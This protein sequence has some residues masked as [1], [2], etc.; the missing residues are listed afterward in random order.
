MKVASIILVVV[1]GA[2]AV[3]EVV[4]LIGKVRSKKKAAKNRQVEHD[5]E[6]NGEK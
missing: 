6:R 1:L 4:S 3:Y 5:E 2:L